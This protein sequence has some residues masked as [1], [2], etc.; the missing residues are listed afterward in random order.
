[1][2]VIRSKTAA[3]GTANKKRN[4][5]S[6]FIPNFS[7]QFLAT[8]FDPNRT[9][10]GKAQLEDLKI[11]LLD[12]QNAGINWKFIFSPVPIQNLG[13]YDSANRWEGYAAERRDLL[14]FI[15]QNNIKNVVFVSGGAGG[16]IVN[17]LTYQLNF[18]QPQIPT[19]AIEITVGPIGDQL[20]LGETF[21]PG[22][23]GSEIMNFSSID[24]IS[25]DTKDIYAG[26]DT[27]SSQ[28]QFVQNILNNQLNQFGYDPIGLDETKV[29]AELIKGSYFAVHNFGWTEFIVDPQS[30]KLQ[31]N[32]YGIDPYTQTDIQSIPADIINRQPEI[33]SQFVIDSV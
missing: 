1:M 33:I 16:T 26:L 25:Q 29:N 12:S 14:Q 19:D 5:H 18:D 27:A 20:D 21:I 11:N 17:E 22:T 8:S 24:T 7:L 10:L 32:V 4:P 9:L 6:K 13:L 23:W 28:D 31:V 30:Q 2:A 15:D 3:T